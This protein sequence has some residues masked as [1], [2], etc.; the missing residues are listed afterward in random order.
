MR[1]NA[2]GYFSADDPEQDVAVSTRVRL[3]RNIAN[4]AFPG[5][6]S[7]KEDA[8]VQNEIIAAFA[9]LPERDSYSVVPMEKLTSIEK[10]LFIE[11]GVISEN[12]SLEPFRCLVIKRGER[13]FAVMN[14]IEHLR[15]FAISG[16]YDPSRPYDELAELDRAL[17]GKL[18]FAAAIDVGYVTTK[19]ENL[20]TGLR[21]SVLLHLPGLSMTGYSEKALRHALEAGLIV[22]G[23]FSDLEQSRGAFYI[24]ANQFAFAENEKKLIE[25]FTTEIGQVL[26]LE[27]IA[28]EEISRK[29]RT[30]LED[31]ILRSCGT[32]RYCRKIAIDEA[33][34][35]LGNL[36]F[37]V[38]AGLVGGISVPEISALV[39]RVGIAHV[40]FVSGDAE[41]APDAEELE[42][43][44]ARVIREAVEA[45]V[46]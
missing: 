3:S 22:K 15:A 14:E 13:C 41:D 2:T 31:R 25:L 17:E 32:L 29:R 7:L 6:M 38:S 21:I 37:G 12:Y 16:G 40:Q 36:R 8:D 30:D 18:D 44:R 45:A 27:R 5:K 26:R 33:I 34:E 20:G 9:T 46:F 42:A 4:R 10:R 28:R 43:V 35:H 11:R 23:F 24:L 39:N 19:L 1:N